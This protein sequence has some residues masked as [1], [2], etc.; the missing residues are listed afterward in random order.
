MT[1]SASAD[2]AAIIV[3]YGT[4]DLAIEA[5]SSLMAQPAGGRRVEVHLVDNA[6]PG[7]DGARIATEI[8]ERGWSALV[9]LHAERENH[10]FGRGNNLVLRILASRVRP[11]EFVFL[12]N[13]DARIENDAIGIL[14]D[15][16]SSRPDVAVAGA[17][18]ERP[19]GRPVASAFRFPGLLSTFSEA[20]CFGPITRLLAR[21]TVPLAPA[22]PTGPVDWVS[23]AAFLARSEALSEVGGFDPGFFLYYEEVDLMLRLGRLG[24]ATWHVAEARVSHAEGVATGVRGG[25]MRQRQPAYWYD[26]WR[27]YFESNHGRA[28]ALLIAMARLVGAALNRA[29][30]MLRQREPA[31]PLNFFGDFWNVAVRPLLGLRARSYSEDSPGWQASP[32]V[33]ADEQEGAG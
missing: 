33:R 9:T 27:H 16:L 31:A 3:N 24:W 23:G 6:S 18:I 12:L 5:I 29:I 32:A 7:G 15:F 21:W 20:V 1:K 14:A 19:D 30:S 2:V 10:G 4:A 17:R 22:L 8:F 25:P 26:S 13:P 28:R 11:P